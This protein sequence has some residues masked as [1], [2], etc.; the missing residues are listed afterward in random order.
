[1]PDITTITKID[2][3]TASK[4][5]SFIDTSTTLIQNRTASKAT[6]FIDT[7]TTSKAT[8][9]GHNI[10]TTKAATFTNTPTTSKATTRIAYRTASK[11]TSFTPYE[12]D[13]L[14]EYLWNKI[15][16]NPCPI[17]EATSEI[18]LGGQASC[19][20]MIPL[21]LFKFGVLKNTG[22]FYILIEAGIEE[23]SVRPCYSRLWKLAGLEPAFQMIEY[24]LDP[25]IVPLE[26]VHL[27]ASRAQ[28]S[29]ALRLL[30]QSQHRSQHRSGYRNTQ[31]IIKGH[32][33]CPPN[34]ISEVASVTGHGF[35]IILFH[36]Y[37]ASRSSSYG[38]KEV[39]LLAVRQAILVVVLLVVGV[40]VKVAALEAVLLC[41]KVVEVSMKE[42]ALLAVRPSILVVAVISGVDS[43]RYI[44]Q[45]CI[46]EQ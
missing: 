1:M 32:G 33:A 5:T 44:I 7:S 40:S 25:A 31:G 14:A 29:T 4:A 38:V 41:I 21:E 2:S 8:T 16:G 19:P 46:Q 18:S 17:T 20:L 35:P 39:T 24:R 22:Y 12:E 27:Q 6:P 36:R 30:L 11:A 9:S 34:D 10:T 23:A 43:S 26:S 15:I 42:V 45:F 3:R 37:S 13:L 28:N